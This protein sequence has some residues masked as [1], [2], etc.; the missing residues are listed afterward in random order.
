MKRLS[1]FSKFFM[2]V[3]RL[4]IW[5]LNWVY[6]AG[7]VVFIFVIFPTK[8]LQ[9]YLT[10]L[11]NPNNVLIYKITYFGLTCVFSYW[12]RH[13]SGSHLYANLWYPTTV[14]H[15]CNKI[16][17]HLNYFNFIAAFCVLSKILIQDQISPAIVFPLTPFLFISLIVVAGINFQLKSAI[18]HLYVQ[19]YVKKIKDLKSFSE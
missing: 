1:N 19:A 18:R 12:L 7:L 16:R 9:T 8:Y 11:S 17:S 13:Y 6:L 3:A 14:N 2:V 15:F 10:L 5:T 4:A